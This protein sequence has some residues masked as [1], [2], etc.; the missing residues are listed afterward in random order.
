MTTPTIHRIFENPGEIRII[1][2]HV[3]DIISDDQI[4]WCVEQIPLARKYRWSGQP[5]ELHSLKKSFGAFLRCDQMYWAHHH[6]WYCEVGVM[7]LEH[8]I[9]AKMILMNPNVLHRTPHSLSSDDSEF[10]E[11]YNQFV[12]SMKDQ[13]EEYVK[14]LEEL[15]QR[16]PFNT[17]NMQTEKE[18][19]FAGHII[20]LSRDCEA[21]E[22]RVCSCR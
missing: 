12:Q 15:A 9:C 19:V 5:D 17:D 21:C 10:Q 2:G 20:D 11:K 1:G 18:K 3:A 4:I 7:H 22:S 13:A 8:F 14:E 16:Q 6:E